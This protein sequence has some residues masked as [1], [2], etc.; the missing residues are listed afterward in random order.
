[1]LADLSDLLPDGNAWTQF[2]QELRYG[3]PAS[4]WGYLGRK[5]WHP[6]ELTVRLAGAA[7][8]K[9]KARAR[10]ASGPKADTDIE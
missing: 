4:R 9:L 8:G 3:K 10:S 2:R 5:L 6:F 7:L 1:M